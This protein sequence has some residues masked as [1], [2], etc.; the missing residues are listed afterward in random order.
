MVQVRWEVRAVSGL[1]AV[2]SRTGGGSRWA[3]GLSSEFGGQHYDE[4]LIIYGGLRFGENSEVKA[5]ESC[6]RSAECNVYVGYQL[7]IRSRTGGKLGEIFVPLAGRR[8]YANNTDFND[9]N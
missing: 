2:C 9:S 1:L 6:I 5:V 7:T 3:F 4:I 8:I